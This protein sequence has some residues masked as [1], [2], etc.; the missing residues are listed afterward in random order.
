[1]A[2]IAVFAALARRKK[3]TMPTIQPKS[4]PNHG[5][6]GRCAEL[7][8]H[9]A[10]HVL[11]PRLH[12]ASHLGSGREVERLRRMLGN[13]SIAQP[14]SAVP[15][16]TSIATGRIAFSDVARHLW[17]IHRRPGVQFH[18]S[19]QVRD[20]FR[21]REREDDPDKLDPERPKLLVRRLEKRGRQMRHTDPDQRHDHERR[22]HGQQHREAPTVFRS[23]IIQP[24][25]EEQHPNRG[26]ADVLAQHLDPDD[27][28]RA[29]SDVTQ[30][31][32]AAERGRHCQIG[33]QEQR[34]HDGEKTSLGAGCGINAAA[35]REMAANDDV[36]DTDQRRDGADREDDRQRGKASG[37]ERQTDDV[38]L[39]CAP[40]AVEKSGGPL[41]VDV[42]GPMP[43]GPYDE[44][45]RHNL[46][47][48]GVTD[49]SSRRASDFSQM[50]NPIGGPTRIDRTL[51]TR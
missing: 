32:P 1:M 47:R 22:R 17:M 38:G 25:D 45:D 49:A 3:K 51:D 24:P 39:A 26:Q 33:Q 36:V 10:Q 42:P 12:R 35:V 37:E 34:A 9:E 28:L 19:R 23:E 46:L 43:A 40:V 20:R 27:L 31:R 48:A 29:G 14:R 21:A 15:P 13:E 5:R 44:R 41:P 18:H 7:L 4:T 6:D 16:T 11:V 8:A 30:S 2:T 50:R